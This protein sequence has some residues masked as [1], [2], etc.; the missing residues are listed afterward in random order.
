MCV[1]PDLWHYTQ[2]SVFM[3][4][5]RKKKSLQTEVFIGKSEAVTVHGP[6]SSLLFTYKQ[7]LSASVWIKL[8]FSHTGNC[9]S[10]RRSVGRR[11]AH[12]SCYQL[13][14]STNLLLHKTPSFKN[15]YCTELFSHCAS[16]HVSVTP[17]ACLNAFTYKRN[18]IQ[19]QPKEAI[20]FI[21]YAYI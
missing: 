21:T 15:L 17:N 13:W 19:M 8:A 12:K 14:P 9:M 11:S 4:F 2:L 10:V 7:F 20:F 5:H 1:P 3:G 18:R 6:H 16:R